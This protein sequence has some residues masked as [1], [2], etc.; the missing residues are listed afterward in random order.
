MEAFIRFIY[1]TDCQTLVYLRSLA[2]LGMVG[3]E[4]QLAMR[5]PEH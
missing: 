3:T 1:Q 2:S 5:M 4:A